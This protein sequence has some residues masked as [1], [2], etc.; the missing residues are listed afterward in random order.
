LHE[1]LL[2][3]GMHEAG[4]PGVVAH[5]CHESCAGGS[6]ERLERLV[7]IAPRDGGGKLEVELTPDDRGPLQDGPNLLAQR[8]D[9]LG[10]E[11]RDA[12]RELVDRTRF[13]NR[14][15]EEGVAAGSAPH[16]L[17]IGTPGDQRFRLVEGQ[18]CELDL[19]RLECV[20]QCRARARA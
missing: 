6:V 8:R 10:H 4:A 7:Q 18:S 12:P 3:K 16:R 17:G 19:S 1:G 20:C 9:P 5:A 2:D 14:L 15:E 11:L 13:E